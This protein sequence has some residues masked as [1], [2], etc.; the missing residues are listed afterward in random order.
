ML[1]LPRSE[2]GST[3]T[4]LSVFPIAVR[5]D[6][7]VSPGVIA[8][9][10]I[11]L[12]LILLATPAFAAANSQTNEPTGTLIT[13]GSD[14]ACNYSNLTAATFANG[15]IPNIYVRVA[16]NVAPRLDLLPGRNMTIEGGYD[17]CSDT[18]PSGRTTLNG[19]GGSGS[20]LFATA[21]YS[22]STTYDVILK[23]LQI[24][25]GLG[26]GTPRRGGGI[27]I[28]GPFMVYLSNTVVRDNSSTYG[29]G[30]YIKGLA[31]NAAASELSQLVLSNNSYIG[32][33]SADFGGGVAC[34]DKA[35]VRSYD[36]SISNNQFAQAGGGIYSLGCYLTLY[37]HTGLFQGILFNTGSGILNAGGGIY[38]DSS[39]VFLRGGRIGKGEV[40]ANTA[41]LGGGIYLRNNSQLYA[42]DASIKLNTAIAGGGVYAENSTTVIARTKTGA[43][44]HNETRC[45]VL[46]DNRAT[47]PGSNAGGG[48]G[49]LF[50]SGGTTRI[51][52]TFIERNQADGGRGMAVRVI[53]AGGTNS[54]FDQ[55]G[56]RLLGSVVASNTNGGGTVADYASIVEFKTSSG[57][58]GFNTFARN[59]N[60][61]N[62]IYTPSTGTFYGI[63]VYG[64]IFDATSGNAAGPGANGPVPLGDCNRLHESTSTFAT[65]STRS[66]G[67]IPQ[68][69]DAV[70]DDYRLGGL[71]LVDWCDESFNVLAS[72][73]SADGGPRPYDDPGITAEF[74]N[75]DLG[76]LERH[77]LDLIFRN[78]FD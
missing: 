76:G 66:N 1:V 18:T 10:K 30:V 4:G 16:K 9:N 23:D 75:Y 15:A 56:L 68:F 67:F 8:V 2:T 53:N 54:G 51:S 62:I 19:T 26:S 49:G 3:G 58:A 21:S 52:G 27:T 77:P 45:S 31:G 35:N 74:G 63:D 38:A 72:A 34:E 36:S 55:N 40:S 47:A 57:A 69:V 25:G 7:Q 50:A 44:C 37:E 46:S 13:V 17:T 29:G 70:N 71:N 6:L 59:R 60:V 5:L 28:N 20:V 32:N 64:S 78:G 48:G 24:S 65:N 14:A 41:D 33:N 43:N 39:I 42:Y 11:Y 12:S 22:G 61:F 73:L